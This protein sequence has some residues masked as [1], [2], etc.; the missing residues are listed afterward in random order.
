MELIIVLFTNQTESFGALEM[1]L[2][3]SLEQAPWMTKRRLKRLLISKKSPNFHSFLD[4][5]P[6]L[7]MVDKKIVQIACGEDHSVIYKFAI[8]LPSKK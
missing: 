7:V 4:Y 1:V 5:S 3:G 6:F 2:L 8:A